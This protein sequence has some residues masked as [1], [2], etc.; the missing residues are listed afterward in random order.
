MT[1]RKQL[2][3]LAVAAAGAA[4]LCLAA[5]P[6]LAA[7]PPATAP[8]TKPAEK[9]PPEK[10]ITACRAKAAA[11]ATKLDKSFE[12]VVRPPFVVAGDVPRRSLEACADRSVVAPAKVR[13]TSYFNKKPDKVITVLLFRG[14]KSY[15]S[16]AKKLFNDDRLPHFGYY[17]ATDQTLVMNI[18]TGT[19]TLV[20]ELTHALIAYDFADVPDWFNE[21]LASLHEQC[22]V[23]PTKIIGLT[24]W[25]LPALQKA[26]KA[27]KLR[28][29]KDLVTVRDFYGRQQGLNYAQA[30]YFCMYMQKLGLL[31]K[32][33]KHFR[34]N[35]TGRDADVKAI[36]HI[37]NKKLPE[38]EKE[39][40][41]WVMTLRFGR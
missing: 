1:R 36:E 12:I 15:R 33:Y 11:L 28:P 27:G 41:A 18:S 16:W 38:I 14:D 2:L 10:L 23:A 8:A 29:L 3:I 31:Q 22:T 19:G 35:H 34:A 9:Y 6:C 37:F 40:I 21:G 13:W 26:I 17:R 5:W 24:N 7:R 30:R 4:W 25:R 32:F 39:Y 20:H